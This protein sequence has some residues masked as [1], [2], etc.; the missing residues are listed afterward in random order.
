MRARSLSAIVALFFFFFTYKPQG[1]YVKE[2]KREKERVA[3][4]E[5]TRHNG[6]VRVASS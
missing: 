2:I 1:L 3:I 5:I 6:R 4:E